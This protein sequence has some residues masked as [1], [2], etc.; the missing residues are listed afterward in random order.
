LR[1]REDWKKHNRITFEPQMS[2]PMNHNIFY[3]QN[4]SHKFFIKIIHT[5]INRETS[6]VFPRLPLKIPP[7]RASLGYLLVRPSMLILT[8]PTRDIIQMNE[9]NLVSF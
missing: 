5:K 7:Q 1:T 6:H 3:S 4:N 8:H 2:R 9:I